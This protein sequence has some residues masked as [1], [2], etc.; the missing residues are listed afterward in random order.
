MKELSL[1]YFTAD[2]EAANRL[3]SE[4]KI[5]AYPIQ[6]HKFPDGEGKVRV[7][8]V[9]GTAIIYASLNTPN[10][11]LIYLA[12][13]ANALKENAA[14]RVILV[15]PYLCYMRQDTAFNAGE[16]ISQKIIGA[17][18][19]IYFERLITIDPHAHRVEDIQQVF[20]DCKVDTLSASTLIAETIGSIENQVSILLVGPD[21]ESKQWVGAIADQ[22]NLPFVVAE[23]IRRDD[24]DVDVTFHDKTD[25]VGKNTFIIDDII[26]SGTTI[27]K[28]AKALIEMGAASV[29]VFTTHALCSEADLDKILLAGVDGV[30]STDSIP[31]STNSI[32]IARLLAAALREEWQ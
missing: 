5:P 24:R 14:D 27:I 8:P 31:H 2:V 21:S 22:V 9:A 15:A 11:K 13:A 12:F 28:C 20:P 4:L 19:S 7:T 25:I 6:L 30:H 1:H 3:A 17:Y 23:K 16:A 32:H 18:L 10:D 26:S 29:S